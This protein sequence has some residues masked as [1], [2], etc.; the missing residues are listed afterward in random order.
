MLNT[1]Y[2]PEE[3]HLDFIFEQR[4]GGRKKQNGRQSRLHEWK[5]HDLVQVGRLK[6]LRPQIQL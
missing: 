6:I 1:E 3:C 4:M 2:I 5:G